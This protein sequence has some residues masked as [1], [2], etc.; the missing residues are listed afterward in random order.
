M[1][2]EAEAVLSEIA[3]REPGNLGLLYYLGLLEAQTGR[4]DRAFPLWRKVVVDAPEESLHRRLAV[5]QVEEAAWRPDICKN[6]E[7]GGS[8]TVPLLLLPTKPRAALVME[9]S[10]HRRRESTFHLAVIMIDAAN[11]EHR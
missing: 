9:A 6:I 8:V 3:A 7:G 1:T 2:P 10:L 5:T 11:F 4:P